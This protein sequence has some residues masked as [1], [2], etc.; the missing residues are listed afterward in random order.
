MQLDRGAWHCAMSSAVFDTEAARCVAA[1]GG[2]EET[3]F[4]VGTQKLRGNNHVHVLTHDRDRD[5][6]TSRAIFSHH[7]EIWDLQPCPS[8][9]A[10]L[11]TI[12]NPSS[13]SPDYGGA[14]WRLPDGA[15]AV[16]PA[17]APAPDAPAPRDR[18]SLES[19]ASFVGLSGPASCARW[20]PTK[21]GVL[22][23][24]DA[25]SITVWSLADASLARVASGAVPEGRLPGGGGWDPRDPDA[26]AVVVGASLHVWDIRAPHKGPACAVDTAHDAQ[27]R[28]AE[29]HPRRTR[30][31]ATCGDDG[32]VRR[33]DLRNP[34]APV[35]TDVRRGHAHWVWTVR[36]N[37]VYES[38]FATG[39]SDGTAR[40]WRDGDGG[41]G[42]GDR[43]SGFAGVGGDGNRPGD[44][45]EVCR[46][47]A[48]DSVY[49]IA[50]SAADPWS[51]ASLSYDGRL[52]VN[53]VPRAEKYKI[54]L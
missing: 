5:V 28:D 50:W 12:Y 24:A 46:Y 30:E 44:A 49:G 15:S 34:S 47:D 37:P 17:P 20:N 26:F 4:L 45:G 41:A 38:L 25:A 52:A 1:V 31:V 2:T 33:W 7:P 53:A 8:D 18:A 51:F 21:S 43:A 27:A 10:L 23:T 9:P 13:G 40:L 39:S 42:R 54:L 6:V 36:H 48:E 11:A 3:L 29:F 35:A 19:V 16:D 22:A 32:V 14:V